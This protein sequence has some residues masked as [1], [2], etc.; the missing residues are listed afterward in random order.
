MIRALKAAAALAVLGVLMGGQCTTSSPGTLAFSWR[1]ADRKGVAAG[2]FTAA[3]NGCSTAFVDGITVTLD[4]TDYSGNF[5][6]VPNN[7]PS[8]TPA[9]EITDVPSGGHSY[10]VNAYRGSELV[11]QASGQVTSSGIR[12]PVDVTLSPAYTASSLPIFF[13]Q[14]GTYS[15]SGTPWVQYQILDAYGTV[16]DNATI[17][18]GNPVACDPASPHF[19]PYYPT[20][21]DAYPFGPY[22]LHYLIL[23]SAGGASVYQICCQPIDHEGFAH[24]LNLPLVGATC[25]AV[26]P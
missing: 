10:T 3:N 26:C 2:D 6:A 24:V 9:V 1:F 14:D 8:G 21:G 4:G 25:P 7:A 5:C 11:F 19:L 13:T 16:L 12:T 15:C 22:T 23:S 18:G 20:G 17:A